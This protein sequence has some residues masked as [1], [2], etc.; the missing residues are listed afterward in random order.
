MTVRMLRAGD[1]TAVLIADV[2]IDCGIG[3]T[4]AAAFAGA[5]LAGVRHLLLTGTGPDCLD[6]AIAA[7]IPSTVQVHEPVAGAQF[8]TGAGRATAIAADADR[9]GWLLDT[10]TDGLLLHAP[11]PLSA[12]GRQSLRQYGRITLTCDLPSRRRILVTGGSRSGKSQVAEDRLSGHA[13]VV[14]VATGAVPDGTDAEWARRIQAHRDRRPAHWTTTETLDVAAV[15]D[16]TGPPVLVDGIGTWLARVMD[17]TGL[18]DN[19]PGAEKAMDERTTAL[20][21]AWGRT[22]RDVVVVTDEVGSGVVPATA[23]GRRF[24]DELGRLNAALARVA[25]EVWL[26]TAGIGQRL[27]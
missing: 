14:Y 4:T 23:S 25:D 8:S 26:V 15:L 22:N 16:A 17:E 19:R 5:S 11:V 18:W 10:A 3:I 9:C 21:E 27:R 1:S 24:R 2:L 6:P 20:I 12:A 13:N 7:A